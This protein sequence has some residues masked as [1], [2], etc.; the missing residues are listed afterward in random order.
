MKDCDVA[1][2]YIVDKD[3]KFLLSGNWNSYWHY[4]FLGQLKGEKLVA[5]REAI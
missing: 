5:F 1:G 4:S 2:G 3:S